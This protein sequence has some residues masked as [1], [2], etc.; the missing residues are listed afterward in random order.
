[1]A[2]LSSARASPFWTALVET[3]PVGALVWRLSASD[4]TL[5][6]VASNRAA[7]DFVG[8]DLTQMI[9]RSITDLFPNIAPERLTL[10]LRAART[11]I[12]PMPL[13]EFPAVN[14]PEAIS[15]VS[16]MSLP[17]HHVGVLIERLTRLR[18][19]ERSARTVT[20]FLDSIIENIPLMVFLKDAASLQFE[21]FN[22]AGEELLGLSRDVLLGKNDYDL[23]PKEQAD[24]FQRKDR[25][26]L[27]G[28]G[29]VDIAEEPIET[30]HGLRW[31][32]TKKIPLSDRP[33]APPKYLLGISEDITV[34]RAL[35]L[36]HQRVHRELEERVAD[37]TAELTR[38]NAELM[39]EIADR[40]RAEQALRASEEQLRQAQKME[41]I[42]RLAGGVAHDFNN[43]LSVIL[44]Y[45]EM[46]QNGLKAGDPM[47]DD[48]EQIA[49]AGTRARQLTQQLLAF[50]RQQ[51]MKLE[52]FDLAHIVGEL[53]SMLGRMLGEDIVLRILPP[54]KPGGSLIKADPGQIEQIILNLAVNARDAM[55]N[56]GTLN[57]EI[58]EI[59]FD[60]DISAEHVGVKAGQYVM[61]AVSDDGVGMDR[62]V[63]TRIFE[64]FFTT[65]A[66]G[67]GTGLGLSTVFGIVR[68]SGGHIWVYSEP[69]RGTT[70][71]IYF[72]KT[73]EPEGPKPAR[74]ATGPRKS[75]RGTETILL[76]EDEAQV[77]ILARD[78]LRRVGYN[79]ILAQNA[80][81]ALL[82][83]DQ[84]Q[85][86]IHLLL[87][88]VIMPHV[89]GAELVRRLQPKRPDMKVLYMSGYTDNTIVHHG[90]LDPGISFLEKP[91]TP[92]ALL[93]KVRETLEG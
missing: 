76:V 54:A 60:G 45:A 39:Q 25:E 50:S 29:V 68:Q 93:N 57:I 74:L 17:D 15:S 4:Q 83:S 22:R 1:V 61:L 84:H 51:V 65:K 46:I 82:L 52:V 26:A 36:S 59:S 33:G 56:G 49:L 14:D 62:A 47:R 72:P 92:E 10:Y 34:R 7:S 16:L 77:R 19:T 44:S 20:A 90:I 27:S 21:R 6:L 37:R 86:R 58:S 81:E 28:N 31:L 89:G 24:F 78:L 55:P 30:P 73:D 66:K 71:K 43:L 87:T 63:Q 70:F 69:G 13:G 8:V 91:I 12:A 80:G 23:F 53:D 2:L 85:G 42:G 18:E 9:G 35:D 64:P 79:V 3:M 41:A 75:L 88:D 32:H 38:A 11:P 40:K 67:K 48:A 5:T